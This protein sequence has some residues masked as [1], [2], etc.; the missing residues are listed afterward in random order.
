MAISQ[1]TLYNDALL[2]IGQRPLDSLTGDQPSREYLDEVYSDPSAVDV[3]LELAKP[4]FAS[5]TIKLSSP[6][7]SADH[8][9]DSVHT[10]PADYI[11]FVALYS[12]DKLDQP[13]S[14][15]L[16]E[17]RTLICEYPVVYLRYITNSR[18][19]TQWT[20]FFSQMVSTYL[21]ERI[22][23]KFSPDI[24]EGLRQLW[25]DTVESAR[26][27][28]GEKEPAR[29]PARTTVVLT[30]EWRKVYND[31]LVSCMGLDEITSNTDDSNRRAKLDRAVDAGAVETVLEDTGWQFAIDGDKITYDPSLE[32]EWGYRYVFQKPADLLRLDGIFT[33]EHMRHPLKAYHDDAD[34]W[35]ADHQ[36]LY[37]QYVSRDYLT[38]ITQWPNFFKRLVAARIARDAAPALVV[39]GANLKLA[40]QT[41]DERVNDAKSNDAMQSPPRRLS[42]GSWTRAY[43]RGATNRG[44]PGDF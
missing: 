8:A 1:L 38:S 16:I 31:A 28:E 3:C 23:F 24:Y 4:R 42:R 11:S 30:N 22:C 14:R 2:L 12:D 27:I 5:K 19:M 37:I 35:Y 26:T 21:A 18:P 25:V 29:R 36:E 17:N 20:P 6:A 44:R 10:V 15:Y 43:G 9:L 32:P 7:V 33:D 40:I 41:F 39:E 34:Y 13:I